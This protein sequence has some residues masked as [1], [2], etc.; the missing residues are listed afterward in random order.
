MQS[1]GV[2]TYQVFVHT[3]TPAGNNAANVSWI[4]CLVN[5]GSNVS[6]LP[7]GAGGGRIGNSENN[8]ILAGTTFETSFIWEDPR[9]DGGAGSAAARAAD[10]NIRA[11]QAVAG[12]L[13]DFQKRMKFFGHEVA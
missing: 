9:P 12:A 2:N 4:D 1:S 13:E 6:S 5:S 7:I 11:G 3:P 10:L 8:A